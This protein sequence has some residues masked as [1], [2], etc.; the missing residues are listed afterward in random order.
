VLSRLRTKRLQVEN[1][2]CLLSLLR[3]HDMNCFKVVSLSI[4]FCLFRNLFIPLAHFDACKTSAQ[5]YD[6][7]YFG[8]S[9]NVI[10]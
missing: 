9:E 8:V 2:V 10:G 4:L 3:K 7:T 1:I 5:L 6:I